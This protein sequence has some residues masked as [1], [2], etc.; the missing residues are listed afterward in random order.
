MELF[1]FDKD[2]FDVLP[3]AERSKYQAVLQ[4][5]VVPTGRPF[6]LGDDGLPIPELEGFCKYLLGP[7][8][9]SPKTWATYAS[10]IVVFL[11]FMQAQGKTWRDATRED[12]NLYYTVRTTGEFQNK[13]PLKASHSPQLRHDSSIA[14]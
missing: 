8:R 13:P 10:Q 1:F 6:F 14:C 5:V 11:R 2:I 7:R 4:S 3:K 12:L 9:A